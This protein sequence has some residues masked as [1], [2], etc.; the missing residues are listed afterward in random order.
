MRPTGRRWKL[1]KNNEHQLNGLIE[2]IRREWS[3]G[4]S[5]VLQFMD[6]QRSSNQNSMIY[7]LYGDI[8]R[9]SDD[10]SVNDV[11]T[12]C[13]LHYGVPILRA[14]DESFRLMWDSH[15]LGDLISYEKKI[16][17]MVYLDVTSKFTKKQ[18]TEYIET[19]LREY[20]KR[21]LLLLDPRNG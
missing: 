21:G 14:H 3:T 11:K 9:Q 15:F 20:S 2:S 5:V 6:G 1:D 10:L 7:A 17:L 18:A 16:E 8:A 13:K 12:M 4:K 19:I